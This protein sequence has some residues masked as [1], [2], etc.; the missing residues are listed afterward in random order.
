MSF[1]SEARGAKT[2]LGT[3]N[4]KQQRDLGKIANPEG[5]PKGAKTA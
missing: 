1:D 4:P 3:S 2:Y 5:L